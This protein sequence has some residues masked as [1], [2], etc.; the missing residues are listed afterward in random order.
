MCSVSFS[1]VFVLLLRGQNIDALSGPK[2][3][4]LSLHRE[5][6]ISVSVLTH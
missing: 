1:V 6:L 4:H 2:P 3:P 5:N